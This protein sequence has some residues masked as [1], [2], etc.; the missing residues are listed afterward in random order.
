MKKWTISCLIMIVIMVVMYYAGFTKNMNFHPISGYKVYMDGEVIGLVESKDELYNLINEEQKE[1]KNTYGVDQVYPPKGFDINKYVSYDTNYVTTGS[2]YN[3]IKAN[4]DFTIKGYQINVKKTD[5]NILTINV[6]DKQIFNDALENIIKAFIT[7]DEYN[8]YKTNSQEEITDTGKII[9]N[10]YFEET[11]TIKDAYIGVNE[12][13]Y[14]DVNDLT[15]YL[16]FGDNVK[17]EKYSV[18]VGDTISSIAE[19]NK[20]NSQEFLIANA[21]LNL[22][23]ENALLAIGQ[24]VSIALINPVLSLTYDAIMVEDDIVYYE[25]ETKYDYSKDTSYKVVTQ[26]GVNGVTRNTSKLH[27]TNGETL[28]A[29]ITNSQVLREPV[30]EIT[31]KGRK[32]SYYFPGEYVDTGGDWKWPTNSPYRL[33]S[34]FGYRWGRIHEGIDISGTGGTGSPIYASR[35]GIVYESYWQ[36]T[37]G[38]VIIIDHQNGIFTMYAHLAEKLVGKGQT[39]TAGMKIGTMGC[40][41]SAC[42]GTHLHYGA[43]KGTPYRGG[44]AFNPLQLYQ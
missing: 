5:G 6:L 15:H 7:A 10:M 18:K 34:P 24:E 31:T 44:V 2:I 14:T 4:D 11:I 42:T 33:T 1:I 25:K 43:Y 29:I 21:D 27:V 19:E 30:T 16:L 13:I 17:E 8:A 35:G 23:D 22:K 32:T 26:S 40:T 9:E 37:G 41:G 28:K 3:M 20:L 39:V 36:S 38:N 12:T